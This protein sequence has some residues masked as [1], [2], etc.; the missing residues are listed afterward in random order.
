MNGTLCCLQCQTSNK[1]NDSTCKGCGM[2]L[3]TARAYRY[4]DRAEEEIGHSHYDAARLHMAKA[5]GELLA[6]PPGD[7]QRDA[8]RARAYY[9][10]GRI[11]YH[12][13]LLAEADAELLAARQQLAGLTGQEEM[14]ANV[15]NLLG[16]VQY[17][18]GHE[19]EAKAYYEQSGEV[20]TQGGAH[21]VAAKVSSNLGHI[22]LSRGEI[23]QAV[24]YYE[25][26][27]N[28]AIAGGDSPTLATIY[29]ALALLYAACGPFSRAYEYTSKAL[30]LREQLKDDGRLLTIICDAG[31]VYLAAGRLEEA[32]RY[33]R[34][35]YQITQQTENRM[36]MDGV[37][38]SLAEMNRQ[39]GRNEAWFNAASRA[40]NYPA[41]MVIWRNEAAL[42]LAFYFITHSEWVQARKYI[43]WL[44]NALGPKANDDHRIYRAEALLAAAQNR[45]PEAASNFAA[46]IERLLAMRELTT[47]A[48]VRREYA[49]SLVR[50]AASDPAGGKLAAAHE[51]L[52]EAAAIYQRL[53]LDQRQAAVELEL[54]QL[55]QFAST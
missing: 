20:A 4:L 12:T 49:A 30:D 7:S 16:N 24:Y 3:A 11:Y 13:S 29:L 39:L 33:L 36:G 53:G 41:G 1:E 34:D 9:L 46:A 14:Q 18:Q 26:G 27:I 43:T 8:M 50:E 2:P 55:D 31:N 40:F 5:D 19:Q 38:S 45:W 25:R 52:T 6:N 10:Q 37:L 47:L 23:D 51:Q 48:L 22:S 15:L 28:E 21:K 35:A 32:E 44:R 54:R 42:Q 17:L